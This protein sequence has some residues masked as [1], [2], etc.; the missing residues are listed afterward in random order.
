M[1][2]R[3]GN[4]Q[5]TGGLDFRIAR[6]W[7]RTLALAGLAALCGCAEDVVQVSHLRPDAPRTVA[8]LPFS[9]ALLSSDS[10]RAILNRILSDE[11]R[12]L[13]HFRRVVA[14][15]ATMDAIASQP[16][17]AADITALRGEYAATGVV[18]AAKL[19]A[20]CNSL[21]VESLIYG[22]V[23]KWERTASPAGPLLACGVSVRWMDGR[24]RSLI[25]QGDY[26]DEV[27]VGF[28][29]PDEAAQELADKV[30]PRIMGAFP[31]QY[32]F[33]TENSPPLR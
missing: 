9:T 25:W 11:V 30:I 4:A 6:V 28:A 22:D 27:Q 33:R 2:R 10:G 12:G 15:K 20:I 26:G 32:T 5:G 31:T 29:K 3:P 8:V 14:V 23:T 17:L 13:R 7:I 16:A 18:N 1:S 21:A 24:D 19:R